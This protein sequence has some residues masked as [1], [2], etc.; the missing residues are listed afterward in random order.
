M[1]QAPGGSVSRVHQIKAAKV[2]VSA[3]HQRIL[4]GNSYAQNEDKQS[5]C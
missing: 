1:M 5:S 4:G 2:L 3:A